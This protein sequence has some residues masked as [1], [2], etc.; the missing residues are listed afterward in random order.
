MIADLFAMREYENLG[1]M[2]NLTPSEI[3]FPPYLLKGEARGQILEVLMNVL[4]ENWA[5]YFYAEYVC[6]LLGWGEYGSR[7]MKEL[8]NKY[9]NNRELAL[10]PQ[11]GFFCNWACE[12]IPN[13]LWVWLCDFMLNVPFVEVSEDGKTVWVG[14]AGTDYG[15]P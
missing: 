15:C 5:D 12:P 7:H 1:D 3:T 2:Y 8:Q 9:W 11:Y 13:I 4:G 6:A 14:K 10:D